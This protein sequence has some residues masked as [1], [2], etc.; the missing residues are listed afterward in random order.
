MLRMGRGKIEIKRIENTTNRQVTFSK[1]RTGLMKKAREL[2]VLC[3]AQVSLLVFSSTNKLYE[4][5]SSN[6]NSAIER[7]HK[8][9]REDMQLANDA[10][11]EAKAWKREADTLRQQLHFLQHNHRVL[12]G[13]NLSGLSFQDLQSLEGQLNSGLKSIRLKKEQL[14]TDQIK[15][16]KKKESFLSEENIHLENH[17]ASATKMKLSLQLS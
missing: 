7:Y 14:L 15:E 6:L 4:F 11:M 16:Y 17:D 3:D 10:A 9:K 1:R 8:V 12:L 13:E 2:S 5:S